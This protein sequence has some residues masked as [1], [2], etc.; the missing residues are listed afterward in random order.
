[1]KHLFALTSLVLYAF[2]SAVFLWEVVRGKNSVVRIARVFF[3]LGFLFHTLALIALVFGLN[4]IFLDNG[5][6]YFFWVSWGLALVLFALRKR[7]DYPIVGA[8]AIPLIMLFMGSSS[9]LMH[10]D[11]R[12]LVP[13]DGSSAPQEFLLLSLHAIP[14]L[15][16]VVSLALAFVV[17]VVFVIVERRIRKRSASAVVNPGPNLQI[18]DKLN[19][20]SV[21]FGFAGI[22]L[23]V[24]SG[25]LW[26]ISM[27][28]SILSWDFSILSGFL[29]WFLLALILHARNSW[30]WSARRIAKLTVLATGFFFISVF[31]VLFWSGRLTHNNLL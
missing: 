4:K 12:A 3:R 17:S 31:L 7:I 24:L 22:T 10:W 27:G 13:E 20:M 26:A 18:L 14:A 19:R 6:D 25:S 9:Y 11:A 1:M 2:S 21:L 15:M 16:A 28:R 5:A 8:V 23:V 29:V 30:E